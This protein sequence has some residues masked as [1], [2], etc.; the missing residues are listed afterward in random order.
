MYCNVFLWGAV[1]AEALTADGIKVGSSILFDRDFRALGEVRIVGAV[2]TGDLSC[3]GGR[4]LNRGGDALSADGIT[5]TGSI[6]FNRSFRAIGRVRLIGATIK[7]DLS[8]RDGHF[9]NHAGEA[10]SGDRARI[11]GNIYFD[12][13]FKSNGIISLPAI[14]VGGDLYFWNAEFCGTSTTGF[15]A[16][17][18][19][20]DGKFIWKGIEQAAGTLLNLTHAR[21]GQ[22][23]DDEASW[24]MQGNLFLNG[25]TYSVIAEGPMSA[26]YR[27]RW[28]RRHNPHPFFPQ[29]YEQLAQV[30]RK[31]GHDEEAIKIAIAKED[32]RLKYS[33]LDW[34]TWLRQWFMKYIVHYGY[35]PH[36]RALALGTLFIVLGWVVFQVGYGFDLFSPTRERVYMDQSYIQSHIV[37][38]AYPGFNSFIYSLDAFIPF[39][40]L[41]QDAYWL[42]NA[43]H[44]CS[45]SGLQ[46]SCGALLRNYL[47]IHIGMGW[48]FT[49]LFA[50]GFSGLVRKA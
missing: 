36:H 41:H 22:L 48:V 43:N 18:A 27:L 17:N 7:R 49:T 42:P 20:I 11:D 29:P 34:G 2:I 16:E 32:A 44:T 3:R 1:R 35:K 5:T 8:C 28:L 47:W 21:V 33:Q 14:R 31:V 25:F 40:D 10:L 19:V 23:A 39:V 38:E 46:L 15:M 30:F 12:G 26:V 45:I 24:P 4:I 37:P 13:R 9:L 50:V 6:N